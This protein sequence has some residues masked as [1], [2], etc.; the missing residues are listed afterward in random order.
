[1]LIFEQVATDASSRP[2]PRI[3]LTVLQHTPSAMQRT[4]Q[5]DAPVLL[6]IVAAERLTRDLRVHQ[7]VAIQAAFP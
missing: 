4:A 3:V 2:M 7:P 1:M 6:A 5:R